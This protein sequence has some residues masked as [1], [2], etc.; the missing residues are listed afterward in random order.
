LSTFTDDDGMVVIRGRLTPELGAVV[1][2]AL[3]AA[4]DRLRR[5]GQTASSA[6]TAAEDVTQAQRRAD[7]LGLLAEAALSADPTA[8]APATVIRWCCTSTLRRLWQ[9]GNLLVCPQG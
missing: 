7:A 8:A 1:Q 6:G 9:Q 3:D 2:R 5:E 4:C